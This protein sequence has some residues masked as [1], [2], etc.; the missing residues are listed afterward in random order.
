MES[1]GLRD[2]KALV[3]KFTPLNAVCGNFAKSEII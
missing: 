1:R 2:S 3:A